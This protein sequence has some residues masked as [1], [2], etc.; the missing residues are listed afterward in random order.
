MKWIEYPF[1][2]IR[3]DTTVPHLSNTFDNKLNLFNKQTTKIKVYIN[4]KKK[5]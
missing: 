4:I 1:E 3:N 5:F 2:N